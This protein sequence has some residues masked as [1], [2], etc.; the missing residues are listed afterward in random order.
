MVV[1]CGS[2]LPRCSGN[3][4]DLHHKGSKCKSPKSHVVNPELHVVKYMG[5]E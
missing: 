2:H 1:G 4:K 3:Q 5:T